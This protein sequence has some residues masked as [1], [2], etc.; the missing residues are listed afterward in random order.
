MSQYT[1][2]LHRTRLD[3][4]HSLNN[5]GIWDIIKNLQKTETR[6]NCSRILVMV[7]NLR[8]SLPLF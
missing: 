8:I 4:G 5:N 3:K 6:Q 2:P 1:R 7:N